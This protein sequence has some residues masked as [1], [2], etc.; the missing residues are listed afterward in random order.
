MKGI[1]KDPLYKSVFIHS[2]MGKKKM[3]MEIMKKDEDA[4]RPFYLPPLG[5]KSALV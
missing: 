4:E 2:D 1:A 5:N 3:H